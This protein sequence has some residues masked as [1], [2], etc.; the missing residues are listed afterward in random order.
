MALDEEL[1]QIRTAEVPD[2]QAPE[3]TKE[4]ISR[5]GDTVLAAVDGAIAMAI[6]QMTKKYVEYAAASISNSAIAV[7]LRSSMNSFIDQIENFKKTVL[8]YTEPFEKYI[9]LV[10]EINNTYKM[11]LSYVFDLLAQAETVADD[12]QRLTYASDYLVS[13]ANNL[14]TGI[15]ELIQLRNLIGTLRSR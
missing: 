1:E 7:T 2:M 6:T 10:P 4:A 13:E 3:T 9:E 14:T 12:V 5:L 11:G 8:A 15:S